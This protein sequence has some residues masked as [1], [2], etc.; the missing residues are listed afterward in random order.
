[1]AHETGEKDGGDLEQILLLRSMFAGKRGSIE[2]HDGAKDE[3]EVKEDAEV[4]EMEA[5]SS[6]SY[7][8]SGAAVTE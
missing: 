2:T 6:L 8:S 4:K 7:S 5:M 3:A 1:M